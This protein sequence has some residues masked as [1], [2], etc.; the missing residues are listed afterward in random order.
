MAE[1]A[2]VERSAPEPGMENPDV[3]FIKT[4]SSRL[5]AYSIAVDKPSSESKTQS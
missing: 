1:D 2:S 5:D 3:D 4:L